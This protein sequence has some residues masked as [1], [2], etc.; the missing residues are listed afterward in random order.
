MM[1]SIVSSSK[2]HADLRLLIKSQE[3][4]IHDEIERGDNE[5]IKVNSG[6]HVHM[7]GKGCCGGAPKKAEH[8]PGTQ[9]R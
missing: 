9:L 4:R 2:M 1:T 7:G 8:M 5:S 3:L 6:K